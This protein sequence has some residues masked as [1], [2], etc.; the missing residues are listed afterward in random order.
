MTELGLV[1][2]RKKLLDFGWIDGDIKNVFRRSLASDLISLK[3]CKDFWQNARDAVLTKLI[4]EGPALDAGCGAGVMTEAL[5]KKGLDVYSFDY[6]KKLVDYTRGINPNT[7]HCDITKLTQADAEQFGFPKFRTI[8]LADVIEHIAD[9]VTALR[10]ASMLLETG[11]RV[12]ISVPYHQFF[13]TEGD[14]ARGHYRR[15]SKKQLREKLACAGLEVERMM[16]RSFLPIVPFLLS[17]ALKFRIDHE[18]IS[19]SWLNPVLL[20]YF[21]NIE[22]RILLPL[23]TELICEA[24]KVA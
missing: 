4:R 16:Y 21:R 7:F 18:K 22:N 2:E 5:L 8:L 14:V 13:W 20:W 12:I 24:V 3:E 15:Y 19:K 9:D 6:D 10:K 23:G 17:K 1:F 11:G